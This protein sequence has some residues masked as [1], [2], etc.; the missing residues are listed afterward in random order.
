MNIQEDDVTITAEDESYLYPKEC[1]E[2]AKNKTLPTEG[3]IKYIY[4]EY[5]VDIDRHCKSMTIARIAHQKLAWKA[6]NYQTY[7]K[8]YLTMLQMV[9]MKEVWYNVNG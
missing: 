2:I 7:N 3:E 8:E 9:E 1:R 6:I 4:E 5:G